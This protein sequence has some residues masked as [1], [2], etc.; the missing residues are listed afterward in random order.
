MTAWSLHRSRASF[1]QVSAVGISSTWADGVVDTAWMQMEVGQK[2]GGQ[3]TSY[4]KE[5]QWCGVQQHTKLV[6]EQVLKSQSDSSG[7]RIQTG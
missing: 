4:G 3:K 6:M 1:Q 2:V 5:D 7:V